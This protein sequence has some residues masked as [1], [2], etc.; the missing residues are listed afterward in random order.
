MADTLSHKV[1]VLNIM[2]VKIIGFE[3]IR[4]GYTSFPDFG[5][6]STEIQRG[7][8]REFKDYVIMGRY[9]F[10]QNR[11]CVPRTLLY[12]FLMLESHARGLSGH[13]GCDKT[14]TD[15]E[16]QSYWPSVKSDVGSIAT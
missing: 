3:Q 15:V 1:Q 9:M 6:I 11:L 13:C 7:P 10:F 14:R 2:K 16:Y 8:S 12:E 4:E 5:P